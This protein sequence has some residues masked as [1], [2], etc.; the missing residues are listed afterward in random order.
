MGNSTKILVVAGEASG[1]RLAARALHHAVMIAKMRNKSLELFGIGGRECE[2]LGMNCL[3]STD[4]MSVVGF[5]EVAK[6]YL[7]FRKVLQEIIFL[8]DSKDNRPDI[9]FLIDYPGFNLRLAK[10]A[11]KRGIRVVF[12]VSPQVWA[13]KAS[14]VKDIVASVDDMLVIFPFEVEIYKNAG[15]AKTHFVG[16]PLL[17]IIKQERETFSSREDFAAKFGLDA[18]KNWLLIFP[19]SRR[20]EVEK[21]LRIMGNAAIAFLAKKNWQA[22][23]VESDAVPR[24]YYS[25]IDPLKVQHF[26]SAQNIHELMHHA[27]LGI[28]KSGTTTLEAGLI[29]LPG[30]ICYKTSNLTY[31]VAKRM[32]TLKFIGLINIVLGK[33]LYPELIQSDF[34]SEKIVECLETVFDQNEKFTDQ[35]K[36]VWDI[37]KAPNNSPSRRVAEILLGDA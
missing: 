7:F 18:S 29:G 3:Y 28:L 32:I 16:H 24:S 14:R 21:H 5:L 36:E 15:L 37:L 4:Q 17:E 22:V 13:W 25:E 19:G 11:H 12:Y 35:L 23:V 27:Q 10:E 33:K 20:E 8:L 30:V 31:Q 9:L 26:R 34:T 6:R 2:Q 1:D